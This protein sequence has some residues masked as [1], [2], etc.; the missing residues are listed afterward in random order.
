MARAANQPG[1]DSGREPSA[2]EV[3]LARRYGAERDPRRRRRGVTAAIIALVAV[4]VVY[5]AIVFVSSREQPVAVEHVGYEVID[6][7]LAE[8]TFNVSAPDGVALVCTLEAV[9][10]TFTQV[11]FVEIPVGP[12]DGRESITGQVPT[13]EP[14]ASATV[15]GCVPDPA[16]S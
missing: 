1:V 14:A 3:L 13:V 11:G 16:A 15:V 12:V 7:T 4:L 6:P 8:V 10:E 5:V 2:Q 9:S